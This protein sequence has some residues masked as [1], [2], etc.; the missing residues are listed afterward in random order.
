M[1]QTE[2]EEEQISA[3]ETEATE[4]EPGVTEDVKSLKE[5]LATEKVRAEGN[6]LGWKRAQADFVNYKRRSEQEREE[7]IKSANAALILALLPV[8]DDFER[9]WNAMPA[10]PEG[11]AWVE[12]AKLIERKLR[13]ALEAVGLSQI[14]AVGKPFDP[15][16]HEAVK[17]VEGKEGIIIDE[18]Q[19]GYKLNDKVLRPAKVT[20]GNGEEQSEPEKEE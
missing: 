16:F 4:A 7:L 9:A 15:R 6:L 3:A 10:E 14:E 1:E 17:Q 12:G 20:V 5:A 13:T 11:T 2:P 19:K 8:L 18:F